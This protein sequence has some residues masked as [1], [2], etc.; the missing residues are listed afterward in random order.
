MAKSGRYSADRKKIEEVSAA[1][2][3]EVHD[4]GTIFMLTGNSYTLTLPTAA[5]AGKGWWCKFILGAD[6]AS[7]RIKIDTGANDTV[8]L[9]GANAAGG[10]M[11]LNGGT[12][13][14]ELVHSQ[15]IKGDQVEII[16]D[17]SSLWLATALTGVAAAV[18]TT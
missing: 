9:V 6:L 13:K 12:D 7:G 17:G 8:E 16:C 14:V 15:A 3:I 1:K 18:V 4:C 11:T 10:A 2:T 5:A